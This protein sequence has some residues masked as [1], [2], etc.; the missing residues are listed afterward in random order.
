MRGCGRGESLLNICSGEPGGLQEW[1][2]EE[3]GLQEE[4]LREQGLQKQG[5]GSTLAV[6]MRLLRTAT[7][8][9]GAT[10][11]ANR[12]LLLS[13]VCRT[14]PG[15]VERRE[16]TR[17]AGLPSWLGWVPLGGGGGNRRGVGHRGGMDPALPS[18]VMAEAASSALVLRSLNTESTAR[19]CLRK[20]GRMTLW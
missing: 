17:G 3:Q 15:G 8:S 2:Q 5:L 13:R 7:L 18:L 4:G 6:E 19:W 14:A 20:Q 11:A 1:G 12:A 9:C 16:T 10:S